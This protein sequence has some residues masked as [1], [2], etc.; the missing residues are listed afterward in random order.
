MT[1]INTLEKKT[2]IITSLA[3]GV[4]QK[5]V[6]EEH[7]VSRMTIS[8]FRKKE[9]EA[10]MLM[11]ARI[12]EENYETITDT[13][14]GSIELSHDL[15]V[16]MKES[17][18]NITPAKVTL[19]LGIDKTITNPLLARIGVHNSPVINQTNIDNSI[20]I[21]QHVDPQV[22]RMISA[23]FGHDVKPLIMNEPIEAEA[24]VLNVE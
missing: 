21:E 11:R 4:T 16:K 12:M 7:N 8:K 22:L 2:D 5:A 14:Q 13:I 9:D 15:T 3:R 24:E 10:V 6:A 17:D 23:G 1:K 18:E 19:K 20:N